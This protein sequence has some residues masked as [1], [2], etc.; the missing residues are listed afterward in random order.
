MKGLGPDGLGWK[1]KRGSATVQEFKGA[2]VARDC[3]ITEYWAKIVIMTPLA[4]DH[5]LW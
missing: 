2:R 5:G 1:E 3:L 4:P